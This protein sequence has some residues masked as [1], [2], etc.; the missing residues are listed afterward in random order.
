MIRLVDHHVVIS[1]RQIEEDKLQDFA[2]QILAHEIGHHVYCPADLTDNARLM[3][4]LRKGLPSQGA[5][6]RR[7]ISNLYS[8]LLI[9]DRLQRSAGLSMA[10]VYQAIRT[11]TS[12]CDRLWL[13]YMR[14]YELLWR[15]PSQTLAIGTIDARINL[16][17][18]TLHAPAPQLFEGLGGRRRPICCAVPPLSSGRR[19]RGEGQETTRSVERHPGCRQRRPARGASPR[20][21]TTKRREPYTRPTIRISRAFHPR[22]RRPD[23]DQGRGRDR[24]QVAQRTIAVRSSTTDRVKG[25]GNRSTA[26]VDHRTLLQGT[27]RPASDQVPGARGRAIHRSVTRRA[28]HLGYR[29][30]RSRT[31]TGWQP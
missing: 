2:L 14:T 26:E 16:R 7:F 30:H 19:R 15:L 12:R 10:A 13:L 24:A 27:G 28:R 25:R 6:T 29:A 23:A 18:A 8:D 22:R 4:R 20:S 1:L 3:A 17:R 31:S 21:K 9:N 11:R 5:A